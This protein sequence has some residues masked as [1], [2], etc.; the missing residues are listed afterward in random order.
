MMTDG[1]Y[2][3]KS[4]AGDGPGRSLDY[5]INGRVVLMVGKRADQERSKVHASDFVAIELH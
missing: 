3:G 5:E 2:E 1:G 4:G